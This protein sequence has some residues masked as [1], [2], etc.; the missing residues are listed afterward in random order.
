MKILVA[1]DSRYYQRILQ[2]TLSNWGYTVVLAKNGVQALERLKEKDGPKL[3]II[4]WMMPEMNGL[5]LCKK[6]RETLDN[7][8]IYLIFLTDNSNKEDMIKGLEAGADDY[9]TKP[10]NELELKFRL[11]NGERILNL[12]NR[13]MQLALTDPLTGLLNRRAFVDRLVSEIARYKRLGQP[14]SLIMVDLD[15]FKKCNDTYGHLV[16]DEVLKHVAKCFSQ[17]LRKYDFIGRYGG[18]EFVICTP[19]VDAS[20][21]Y[22]IAERL[23][24]SIKHVNIQQEEGEPLQLY[25]TASFG[26]CEFSDKIK[27]VYD[28]IKEA[29]EAL[30]QAK[31]NGKDQVVIKN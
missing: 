4:D 18:E 2:D 7:S 9:I 17:F 20:V 5:E 28:L 27:D 16:G 12:E 14:L 30:Y 23:R 25:I 26:I 22:T 13:I 1:E 21:A 15:N 3:A 10:F 19:G 8:Y 31:A 11:K 29:D 6:V 24:K